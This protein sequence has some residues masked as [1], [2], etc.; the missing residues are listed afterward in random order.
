MGRESISVVHANISMLDIDISLSVN[1]F[2]M[3]IIFHTVVVL[4]SVYLHTLCI[5]FHFQKSCVSVN[6]LYYIKA[7]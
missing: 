6:T 7:K 3:K 5:L 4:V 1:T 2:T